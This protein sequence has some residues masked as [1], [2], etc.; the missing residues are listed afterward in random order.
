MQPSKKNISLTPKQQKSIID[1]FGFIVEP[2]KEMCSL[3]SLSN[4]NIISD[5]FFLPLL[6][7]NPNKMRKKSMRDLKNGDQWFKTL[8]FFGKRMIKNVKMKRINKK[9]FLK[10]KERIRKGIPDCLRIKVWPKMAEI[11]KFKLSE[12]LHFNVSTL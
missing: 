10:V 12:N 8:S 6:N 5:P 11:E 7:L 2:T 9:N 3:Y 4:T 1:N